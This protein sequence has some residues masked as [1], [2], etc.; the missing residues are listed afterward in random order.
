MGVLFVEADVSWHTEER[1]RFLVDTGATYTVVPEDLADRLGTVRSPRSLAVTLADGSVRSMFGTTIA[2]RLAGREALVTALI[3]PAGS[4]PLLGAEA[5]QVLGLAI[6][7]R[8]GS[9]HP[10]R[11]HAVMAV[12]FQA[13]HG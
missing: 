6:D 5:L 13:H 9:L 4:E 8:D 1:V 2:M 3:A 11:A 12:G 7:P 10:T